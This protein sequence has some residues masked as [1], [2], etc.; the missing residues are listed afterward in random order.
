MKTKATVITLEERLAAMKYRRMLYRLLNR[1]YASCQLT[2]S[3]KMKA[4]FAL[5]MNG[6]RY[7]FRKMNELFNS[8]K[9]GQ[10]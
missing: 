4:E 3:E 8:V 2:L 5:S 10:I 6:D 9:G 7:T 1:W